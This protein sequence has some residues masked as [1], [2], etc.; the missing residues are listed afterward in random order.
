M[1]AYS[2]KKQFVDLIKVGLGQKVDH[3]P[4]GAHVYHPKR[5]TIR[6][7]GKRRHARPG[8][9]LQLYYGMRTKQCTSIGVA[10]CISA[11]SIA[12]KIGKNSLCILMDGDDDNIGTA[13]VGGHIHD[14]AREDGFANGEEML[15]F[16][17]KEHP[18]VTDF[19]GVIIKWEPIDDDR[20]EFH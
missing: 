6:A 11:Q 3:E 4:G 1:V 8:E 17:Q 10:R 20:R 13:I 14:F 2:F 5:Q 18:G 7:I 15:A 12:M 19:K 9:I 16:W